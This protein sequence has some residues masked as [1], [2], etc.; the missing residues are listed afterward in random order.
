[1]AP[2]GMG[3]IRDGVLRGNHHI[4]FEQTHR[5]D[6]VAHPGGEYDIYNRYAVLGHITNY[7]DDD[8]C[9]TY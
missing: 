6:A 3:Q 8:E 1:M 9:S 4:D 2:S 7:D 5:H